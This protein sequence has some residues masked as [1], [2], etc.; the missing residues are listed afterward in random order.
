MKTSRI[1]QYDIKSQKYRDKLAI[2]H[3]ETA[4]TSKEEG[5]IHG[6][7]QFE[8]MMLSYIRDGEKNKL[9]AFLAGVSDPENLPQGKL[10]S[11]PLR[12]AKN[13]LIGLTA[14]VGKVAGIGGGMD[15]EDAYR[16]I[17]IY[18]QECEKC[19]TIEDIYLLQYNMVMDFTE[20]VAEVKLPKGVSK[21]T[22]QAMQYIQDNTNAVISIDDVANEVHRSRSF[23]TRHFK[24]ETGNTILEYIVEAKIKEAKRLLRYSK[25]S[26]PSIANYLCFSSQPYFQTVFKKQTSMTPAEYRRKN[27]HL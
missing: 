3:T 12:Q 7:Y 26:I 1:E 4:V 14:V 16:L 6:T 17:D 5:N 25:R 18:T 23:I 11:D 10:A 19:Q 15:I 22:Y 27:S 8:N 13:L 20:R 24:T 21:E 9:K 2:E